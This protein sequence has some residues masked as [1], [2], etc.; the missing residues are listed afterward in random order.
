VEY[1]GAPL[2]Y[3]NN[4]PAHSQTRFYSRIIEVGLAAR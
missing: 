2:Y 1:E 4:H 3:D